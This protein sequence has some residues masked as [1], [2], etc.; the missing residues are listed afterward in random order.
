MGRIASFLKPDGMLFV[1]IF[2]HREVAFEFKA[3]D[4]GNWMARTF[5]SGGTM[6]S[7]DLLLHF[8]RDLYLVDHWCMDG[9]HYERT[10]RA[11][12]NRLDRHQTEVRQIM[13]DTYGNGQG[14]ARLVDWRLFFITCEETWKL[15]RGREYLVSHYL[16]SRRPAKSA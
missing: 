15:D 4:E 10:L 2:S 3:A 13:E 16:F 5:F 7:D 6:P 12:L 14:L 8:Q 1:H 9:T 11:W